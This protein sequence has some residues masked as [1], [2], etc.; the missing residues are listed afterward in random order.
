M[1]SGF[2]LVYD[3]TPNESG[4]RHYDMVIEKCLR[5]GIEPLITISH[6]EVPFGLT[7]KCN[8]WASR[9]MI[10]YYLN[11]CRTIFRRY[12]GKVR[13]WLTFNEINSATAPMGAFLNQG[14]LNDLENDTEFMKQ[15]DYPQQRYQG[16]HHMFLASA[17]AV[18][19]THETDSNNRVVENGLGARDKLESDGTVCDDYRIEYL[20]QHIEQMKEAVKDGVDL[21]GYTPWGSQALTRWRIN[22]SAPAFTR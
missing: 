18:K 13:Y 20:S 2:L 3:K 7:R 19:L 5:Y 21:M 14:I 1:T 6:Y 15:P 4:L 22:S 12:K 8:G 9:E 10:D 16:L 11:F 17:Q